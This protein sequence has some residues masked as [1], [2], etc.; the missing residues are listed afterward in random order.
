MYV[1]CVYVLCVCEFLHVEVNLACLLCTS[2]TVAPPTIEMGGGGGICT[3]HSI[4]YLS[5]NKGFTCQKERRHD[6]SLVDYNILA[7]SLP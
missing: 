3:I 1:V 6:C 7:D 2:G 4:P 5:N